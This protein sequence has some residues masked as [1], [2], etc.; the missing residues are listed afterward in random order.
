MSDSSFEDYE[1]YYDSSVEVDD[2]EINGIDEILE[3]ETGPP[4]KVC[5]STRDVSL[6]RCLT[7]VAVVVRGLIVFCA[8]RI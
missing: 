6:M 2:E 3:E 7:A 4:T 5:G 1:E 8:A